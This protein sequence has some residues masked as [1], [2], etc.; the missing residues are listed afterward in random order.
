MRKLLLL[1]LLVSFCFSV[2]AQNNTLTEQEKAE[3]W[4]LIFDGKTT[5]GWRGYN[6]TTFPTKGWEIDDEAI[7]CQSKGKGG[8]IIIDKI[9]KDF[10][11]KIDWK[12]AKGANSG[13]FYH[14]VEIEGKPI[15]VS[16]PEIQVLDNENH[17]DAKAGKKGNHQAGSLY[18]ILPAVPQN[19]KP[20]GE[21]NSLRVVVK[22]NW[23][24]HYQNGV[25]VVEYSIEP[26]DW[27]KLTKKCKFKKTDSFVNKADRGYIGL[28]DHGDEVWYRNVKIKEL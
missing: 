15:Y 19:A 25:K 26:S 2:S 17:P 27:K 20:Y 23:V 12:V 22:D 4:A 6:K 28:Q 8:D 7:K 9:Y 3:G 24:E 5:D 16:A 13:V 1:S 18:D 10:E 14:G 11:L 21:W